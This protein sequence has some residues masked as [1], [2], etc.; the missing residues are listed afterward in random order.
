MG[1]QST[2]TGL[3]RGSAITLVAVT[4]F[5]L[6]SGTA[7]G[8]GSL[9]GLGQK[10][11]HERIT[12]AIG[13][14]D[15]RWQPNSLSLLAGNS[16]NLGGVGAPDNPLDS[17]GVTKGSGPGFKHCDDGDYVDTPGYPNTPE[18][19]RDKWIECANYYQSLL[20]RA[21]RSAGKLVAEDLT[22][23][24]SVF[25]ITRNANPAT[26]SPDTACRY[27]FGLYATG[28][29]KCDVMNA[30]GRSLHVAQDVHAHSNWADLADP[31]KPISFENPPGL[32]NTT[33]PSFLR[34]P[35]SEIV[36]PPGLISGCDDT[37]SGTENCKKRVTHSLLAKDNGS[38]EV[39][40]SA[41]PTDK[42]PRGEVK[43]DGVTNFQRAV[44]MGRKQ[45]I[46]T[47]RDF[48]AAVLNTYGD[49]R[50]SLIIESI[51]SDQAPAIVAEELGIASTSASPDAS[52]ETPEPSE[53]PESAQSDDASA[54][55]TASP[56]LSTAETGDS[57]TREAATGD[58]QS[59]VIDSTSDSGSGVLW[60]IVLAL[61]VV[62]ILIIAVLLRRSKGAQQ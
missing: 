40:G 13:R 57:A 22:I 62:L 19:A 39:N 46:S 58:D 32:G 59:N 15:P 25:D 20:S 52:S 37:L 16:G 30:L 11:E 38:I 41:T 47:W 2:S 14:D 60:W 36:I 53:T 48:E 10:G 23:N 7:L 4:T 27:P 21:V 28:N 6:S 55:P 34:Y 51:V 3:L 54:S 8:F 33:I 49:E 29:P 24:T 50:G 42:Y 1:P 35:A 12:R 44:T 61:G 5:V 56:S 43:V 18:K 26:F 31:T 45:S 17:G 9:N